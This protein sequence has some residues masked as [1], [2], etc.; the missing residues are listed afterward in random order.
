MHW[1][2]DA[3]LNHAQVWEEVE[4]LEDHAGTH[5][6]LTDAILAFPTLLMERVS[7]NDHAI[8]LNRSIGWILKEVQAAKEGALP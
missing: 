4:L 3:V 6:H 5:A 1:R 8:N 2:F 7:P